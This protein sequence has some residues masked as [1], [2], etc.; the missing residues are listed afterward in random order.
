MVMHFSSATSSPFSFYRSLWGRFAA[1]SFVTWLS[2]KWN[3]LI[4]PLHHGS[5]H[6]KFFTVVWR[7]IF[8][9]FFDTLLPLSLF[10]AFL[11]ERV[12]LPTVLPSAFLF[13]KKTERK[14]V[15]H[16]RSTS[17]GKL[18]RLPKVLAGKFDKFTPRLVVRIVRIDETLKSVISFL[19]HGM[20]I[21]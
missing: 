6:E 14:R 19:F 13:S 20:M 10:R 2:S 21:Y 9:H 5:F 3:S 8:F 4:Y 11:S 7:V 16:E 15:F 12:S 17:S 18:S 1:A